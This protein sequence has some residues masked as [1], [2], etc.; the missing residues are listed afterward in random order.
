MKAMLAMRLGE[1]TGGDRRR[2]GRGADFHVLDDGCEVSTS[3]LDCPLSRCKHDAPKWY[4]WH[5]RRARD[6]QVW[7]AVRRLGLSTR[8]AAD[9]F[10]TT[11][12]TVQRITS[13]VS[14]QD[15]SDGDLA[16]FAALAESL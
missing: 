7:E 8:E 4:G 14:G 13:R 10:G 12:R 5:L 9:R 3:C 2:R 11:P 6:Y 1:G 15:L 16:V